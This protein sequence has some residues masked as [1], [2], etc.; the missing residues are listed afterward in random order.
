MKIRTA[1]SAAL[2]LTTALA[3]AGCADNGNASGGMS[4]MDH[5]GSSSSSSSSAA[6]AA[7]AN[8]AD[9]MF[10]SM[11]IE[12]HT[13]AID[14]SDTLLAKDGIDERVTAL[15]EQIKAAQQP[16]IDQLQGWLDE[17]GAD[18]ADM[19]ME[20]MDHSGGMMTEEDMQALDTATGT[21]ASRLFLE[22][23]IEH[24]TG[25]IDMAQDQVDNGQNP[26]AVDLA[27]KIIDDQT[28]E[29]A[30]MEDILASL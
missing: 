2:V 12:H 9:I 24:H 20:G 8:D 18:T 7:N 15:A 28:A 22:Q 4:G 29:I 26:D 1:A 6:P 17:W 5:G 16:E 25:A 10:A 14:M 3:L 13:Q 21:E 27:Q 30:T 11:M 19:D 23:M